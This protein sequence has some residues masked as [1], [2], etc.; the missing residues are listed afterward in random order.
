M[1]VQSRSLESGSHLATSQAPTL[2]GWSSGSAS[3]PSFSS[4]FSGAGL[5]AAAAFF[6]WDTF[7]GMATGRVHQTGACEASRRRARADPASRGIGY[8]WLVA[9]FQ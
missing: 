2:K 1:I 5:A 3:S 9:K 8:T 6:R 4:F 7:R